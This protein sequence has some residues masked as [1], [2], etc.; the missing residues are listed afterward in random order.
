MQFP[1]LV[2]AVLGFLAVARQAGRAALRLLTRGVEVYLA[3]EVGQTHARRGDIT[4]WKTAE[5]TRRSARRGR[6]GALAVFTLCV[7]MLAAPPF[8]PWTAALYAAY[9]P[10]WLLN[11]RLGA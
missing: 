3:T 11:R 8:T 5:V 10:L 4:A 9:S 1:L 7:G 2:L 6:F